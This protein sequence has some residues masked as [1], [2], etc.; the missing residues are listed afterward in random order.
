VLLV[1]AATAAARL[2][3]DANAERFARRAAKT[4]SAG[5]QPLNL[6]GVLADRRHDWAEAD[7]AYAEALRRAP[8]NASVLNNWGWSR[9]GRGEWLEARQAFARAAAIDPA[10]RVIANNLE[11]V[12]AGL[13]NEL[14]HRR[15]GENNDDFAARLNDAGVTARLLGDETRATAAFTLAVQA[16]DRWYERAYNNLGS[17]QTAAR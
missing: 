7:R 10:N 5:C 15:T 13:A 1:G 12:R 9:L 8:D 17:R 3:L 4:T 2:G 16:R 14:P 6:L 11:L